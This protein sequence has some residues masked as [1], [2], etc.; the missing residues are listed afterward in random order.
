LTKH[1][2]I[3][4]EIAP[5]I[6]NL[7]DPN[8]KHTLEEVIKEIT[9]ALENPVDRPSKFVKLIIDSIGKERISKLDLETKLQA[10]EDL[11]LSIKRSKFM[12]DEKH[13]LFNEACENSI[14]RNEP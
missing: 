4:N 9:E 5:E 12:T 8:K 11:C 2:E 1:I 7:I 10:L 13:T 6:K 14:K 3:V